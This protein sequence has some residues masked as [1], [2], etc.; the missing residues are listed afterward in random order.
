MNYAIYLYWV[1]RIYVSECPVLAGICA[2]LTGINIMLLIKAIKAYKEL[3]KI[4][5]G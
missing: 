3:K 5:R 4:K 1:V 2:L